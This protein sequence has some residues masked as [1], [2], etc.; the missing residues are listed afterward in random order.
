MIKFRN[1]LVI[2]GGRKVNMERPFPDSVYLLQLDSLEWVRLANSSPDQVL[3]RSEFAAAVVP[4]SCGNQEILI[5]GGIDENFHL[6]NQVIRM[7]LFRDADFGSNVPNAD[8]D[9][10]L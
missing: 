3:R 6:S 10:V 2:L 9:R 7:Q 5:F 8:F 1:Q 4:T